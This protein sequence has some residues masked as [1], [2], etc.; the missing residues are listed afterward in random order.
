[1][2]FALLNQAKSMGKKRLQRLGRMLNMLNAR[3]ET[4]SL[5]TFLQWHLH[6]IRF[7]NVC[8]H[9]RLT[10]RCS[11]RISWAWSLESNASAACRYRVAGV[12]Q[13]CVPA[14][15]LLP[16]FQG[17]QNVWDS[18]MVKSSTTWIESKKIF[19]NISIYYNWQ[20]SDQSIL[21]SKTTTRSTKGF[22]TVL[23]GTFK[24]YQLHHEAWIC[25]TSTLGTKAW[26]QFGQQ[27]EAK[28]ASFFKQFG[29][30]M[31]PIKVPSNH[32]KT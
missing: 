18:Q 11:P 23:S 8:W 1:M 2:Y 32:T 14:S 29:F 6:N 27:H 26:N 13:W 5:H 10:T 15:T 31:I 19:D 25:T 28:N 17:H 21:E 7:T 22:V 3:D 30:E 9:G 20:M 4:T 16:V 24:Q 12:G